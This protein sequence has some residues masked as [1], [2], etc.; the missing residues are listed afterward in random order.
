MKDFRERP[1]AIGDTVV[2][3]EGGSMLMICG[4]IV[5]FTPKSAEVEY[6]AVHGWNATQGVMLK[7]LVDPYVLV[8][9]DA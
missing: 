2:F 8:K 1:L 3:S 4:K 9:V 7:K 6:K 5:R